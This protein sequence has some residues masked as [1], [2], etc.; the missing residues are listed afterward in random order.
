MN[1]HGKP[2]IEVRGLV[3]GYGAVRALDGID[4]DVAEG[5]LFGFLGPNGAGKTTTINILTGL[6]RADAGVLRIGGIDCSRKPKAAQHLMGVVPDESNLYPELSGRDNLLFCAALYGMRTPER[7]AR[8]GE[9]LD[10]LGLTEA[11][12]RKFGGVFEGHEAETH[13]RRGHHAR[14]ASALPRRTDN[15]H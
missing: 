10:R 14:T 11:A 12:E 13:H 4:F 15:R 3:K 8:A 2:V 5:E 1:A 7:T 9:L 6:A